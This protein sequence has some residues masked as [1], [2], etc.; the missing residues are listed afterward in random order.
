M[1]PAPVT[2]RCWC[3]SF[4]WIFSFQQRHA[5]HVSSLLVLSWFISPLLSGIMSAILFFLV[6][7]FILSKV[8]AGHPR[9]LTPWGSQVFSVAWLLCTPA[10]PG[11]PVLA[12]MLG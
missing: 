1:S 2:T 11:T 12:L 7:R 9:F 5:H 10:S 4:P 3:F 6:R 8:S